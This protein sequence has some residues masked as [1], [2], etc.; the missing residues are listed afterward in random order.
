MRDAVAM[1]NFPGDAVY[2]LETQVLLNRFRCAAE[3]A[4][5]SNVG[6]QQEHAADDGAGR[7]KRYEQELEEIDRRIT[8][9]LERHRTWK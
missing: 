3:I 4:R 2:E 7:P 8:E 9:T 6:E 5:L 1:T